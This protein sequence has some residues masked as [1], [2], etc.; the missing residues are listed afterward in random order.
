MFAIPHRHLLL[1]VPIRDASS[2]TSVQMLAGLVVQ[3]LTDGEHG[4]PGG[5]L[6]PLLYFS[7]HGRVSAVSGFDDETGAMRIEVDE[8]FQEALEQ[9]A[10]AS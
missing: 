7:R 2:I 8:R 3:V 6:S 10:A 1:A 4:L 5:V 9:A